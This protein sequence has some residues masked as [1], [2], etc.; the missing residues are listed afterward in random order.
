MK[1]EKYQY[2]QRKLNT[3]KDIEKT[4]WLKSQWLM[5]YFAIWNGKKEASDLVAFQQ[6]PLD[7]A[8]D[9]EGINSKAADLS[10][11]AISGRFLT[12]E[13]VTGFRDYVEWKEPRTPVFDRIDIPT[14]IPTID[15]E[16]CVIIDQKLFDSLEIEGEE[17]ANLSL[18]FRNRESAIFEGK[19]VAL[20]SETRFEEQYGRSPDDDGSDEML[21]QVRRLRQRLFAILETDITTDHKKVS[22][23]FDREAIISSLR[24][25]SEF[26]FYKL[27][28]P[29]PHLGIKVCIR[30][31]KPLPNHAMPRANERRG[32]G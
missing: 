29:S 18:E 9:T 16:A 1:P 28:W 25:P 27:Q 10:V 3:S 8:I 23:M 22:S 4:T 15:L 11:D 7:S 24:L 26:L 21:R 31:E 17:I 2:Y 30:W 32:S 20:D 13:V 14:D 19:D 5:N 12:R 6:S